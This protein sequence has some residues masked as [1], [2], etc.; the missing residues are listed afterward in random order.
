IYDAHF[1]RDGASFRFLGPHIRGRWDHHLPDPL[2]GAPVANSERGVLYAT[3][4]LRCAVAEVFGDDRRVSPSSTQRLAVLEAAQ[5]LD[6]VDTRGLAAVPL[7]VPAG[8]LRA[9]DRA[10][11]QRIARELYAET[12]A[13]GLLYEGWQTGETCVC[14]WERVEPDVEVLDDR[15]L[16]DDPDVALDLAVIADELLYDRPGT[17]LR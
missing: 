2:T 1:Y 5:S 7:G 8:A 12:D 9:R 16:I 14:L 6:L 11:T 10:L 4:T 13:D 15:G 3:L 17:T